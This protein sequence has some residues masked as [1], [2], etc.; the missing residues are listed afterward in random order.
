MKRVFLTLILAFFVIETSAQANFTLRTQRVDAGK[1]FRY[2]VRQANNLMD[3]GQLRGAALNAATA[4]QMARKKRQISLAQETLSKIYPT[5]ISS[6]EKLIND[7]ESATATFND[8]NTVTQAAQLIRVYSEMIML[9]DI[10][11]NLPKKVFK[12]AKKRDTGFQ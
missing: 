7:L 6:N 10:L 11:D 4:L 1:G 12:P 8:D 5:T 2:Y 3:R 9:Y